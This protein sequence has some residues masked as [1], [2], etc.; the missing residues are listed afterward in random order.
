MKST[1]LLNTVG[2][3][4]LAAPNAIILYYIILYMYLF[5]YLLKLTL[6][7]SWSSV[8]LS[9]HTQSNKNIKL[10]MFLEADW[11]DSK[12]KENVERA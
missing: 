7:S 4:F 5:I 10:M 12:I 3:Q 1:P 9:F 11:L 2:N 6:I 8:F